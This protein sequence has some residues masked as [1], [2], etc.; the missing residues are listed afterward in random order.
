M[1]TLVSGLAVWA[2]A[3]GQGP[4]V[5]ESVNGSLLSLQAYVGVSS[6]ITMSLA[7]ALAERRRS[8]EELQTANITLEQRVAERTQE[9][10][11]TNAELE[12]LLHVTSHDLREPLRSIENF[13]LMVKEQ[14]ASRLDEKGQNLLWRIR[15]AASRLDHLL[16][17]ILALSRIRHAGPVVEEVEG[18][19]IVRDALG[20][21]EESMKRTA[22]KVLVAPSLP[23]MRV[24]RRWASEAVYNLVSN[25]LK[26]TREGTVPEI[27]IAPYHSEQS[28]R[29]EV[30]LIVRDR[31]PGV[32]PEQAE[33]I[34]KLFQR[35]VGREIEGTGAGLAIV[36]EIAHQHGGRAWVQPREGS[37]SEFIITFGLD[38]TSGGHS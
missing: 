31:G 27:E 21:L 5:R 20:R 29:E 1:V 25:A 2:T 38:K 7:A 9:L 23:R 15:R 30:G 4:F 17:D 24:D 10:S 22:A 35:A 8:E 28:H 19:L 36:Q 3:H 37:G 16:N 6:L 14:Y 32:A 18:A 26:Y 13:S 11:R 34:F 33:R 12:T